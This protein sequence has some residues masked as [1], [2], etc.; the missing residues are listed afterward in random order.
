LRF[1]FDTEAEVVC[2]VTMLDPLLV[3]VV[4]KFGLL[5]D[6]IPKLFF[7][8]SIVASCETT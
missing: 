6:K 4:I 1:S 2:V 7:P 3:V 5:F 8:N